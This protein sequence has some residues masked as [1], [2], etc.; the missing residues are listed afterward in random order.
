MNFLAHFYLSGTNESFILGNFL[1]DFVKGKKY[2]DYPEDIAQGILLH[3]SIDHY[4]DH[5]PVHRQSKR[6]LGE[7]YGHYAGVA[8][9]MFYDHLLAVNWDSYSSVSLR[10]YSQYVYG[11]LQDRQALFPEK[12][13]YVLKYMAEQNWLY[14]Y[15][16]LE[17]IQRALGGISRRTSFTSGLER[18]SLDLEAQFS[19]FQDDF[20]L[21]FPKIIYYTQTHFS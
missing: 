10:D 20:N 6:R 14:H 4:T 3:R 5:H 17:G 11:I 12:A 18:A 2:Q 15:Q 9:D 19:E 16:Q 21:F 1:G 7:R 13:R 8:V